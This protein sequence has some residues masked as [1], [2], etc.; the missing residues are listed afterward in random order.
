MRALWCI[1]TPHRL[2]ARP[3]RA[4]AKTRVVR[5]LD[6]PG[7]LLPP[8]ATGVSVDL[9]RP[10]YRRG[11]SLTRKRKPGVTRDESGAVAGSGPI[12]RY[13]VSRVSMCARDPGRPQRRRSSGIPGRP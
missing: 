11:D 10:W 9:S 7:R 5:A 6:L 2:D 8:G 1:C 12:F 13:E 4:C 3:D